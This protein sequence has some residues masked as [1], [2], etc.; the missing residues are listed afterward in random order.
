MGQ[1]WALARRAA[2]LAGSAAAGWSAPALAQ[3]AAEPGEERPG[4]NQPIIVTAERRATNLQDTPLS[5]VAVTAET[6]AAKGIDDLAD[7]GSFTPNLNITPARGGGNAT[8]NFS[9]RGISGGGGATSER[10]VGL[11]IDGIFVP[12]T[13]GS[14][15]RVLDID[16]IEVL[17]GPQ[18]TLFGRNSTGGAIRIFTKQP[19]F[20]EFGGYLRTT[21]ANRERIDL[22]GAVN[23]PVNETFAIRGQ[24]AYLHEGGYVRRGTQ[25]LGG[26]EDFVGRV[27]ARYE[28]SDRFD[29]TLGF[30]YTDAKSTGTPLVFTEFDMRPG[31]EPD[32]ANNFPGVQ[33]NFADWLN[34][35][36]KQAGQAPLAAYNDPRIVIDDFT[37]PSICLLDDFDPDFDRACEQDEH[38]KYWQA[39]LRM[40]YDLSDTL[41]LSSVTGLSKLSHDASVDYQLLGTEDRLTDVKST[42]FYQE[43]Q[44]NAELFAGA[45][46]LVTGLNYF[47]EKSQSP[48]RVINRRGSSVFPN[49]PNGDTGD[50]L[51]VLGDNDIEQMSNSYGAFL[52]GTW[53]A[54]DR[55]NLTGG[56]RF[57]YD[58]KDYAETEYDSDNFDPVPG[59]TSTSV[60][61]DDN[62][63]QIDWRATVDYH[64]TDDVMIYATASKAYK[65]G[66]YSFT[67]IDRVPGPEQSGDFIRTIPPEKVRNFEGGLRIEAFD[68]RVRFNP[69]GFFM[70]WTNRQAARQV[71]CVTSPSCP[72]GFEIQVVNSGDIDLYGAEADLFVSITDELFLDAAGAYIEYDLKDP[73]ANSGPNLYPDVP[74]VSFNVGATYN[75]VTPIGEFTFNLNYA[76][77]DE[78][79]THPTNEGDS[80][81]TLPAIELVNA[82]L[83]YIPEGSP[84][85]I[86]VFAN[87]LLDNTYATYAQRFGGGYW[88]QGGPP[89]SLNPIA[90]PPRSAL[91]EVRGRPREVG[92]SLQYNF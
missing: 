15:L 69:T 58:E 2:L 52:S 27:T 29:A 7:L 89:G 48:G 41:S 9:I 21:V 79:A 66:Q 30:L 36:F 78:Q 71:A 86:S 37:A 60:T 70:Q 88:D 80:A 83:Q 72:L 19:E 25:M 24:A 77:T 64:I 17:R 92:L 43:L 13:S 65:A 42:V 81:F 26:S 53:H 23:V 18:G 6:V 87:N 1:A 38:D 90:R 34:D 44:L 47:Y 56:L 85:T 28:P 35:S 49:R 31:I 59:T 91:A 16:R 39:D 82:R 20:E 32:P 54:T 8:P 12:R 46:D 4:L 76:Y 3:V 50:R 22:V 14:V 40:G 73:V 45:V 68:G 5:I 84:V 62:W 67:I 10:G 63:N 74:T 57:A 61:S 75:T 55:L 11:Y 51:F 33:G